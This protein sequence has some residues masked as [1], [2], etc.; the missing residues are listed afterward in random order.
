MLGNPDDS[1]LL[2]YLNRT[3]DLLFTLARMA[4]LIDGIP[5][6]EWTIEQRI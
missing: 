6:V 3:S 4:N 5:D 1:A 2:I